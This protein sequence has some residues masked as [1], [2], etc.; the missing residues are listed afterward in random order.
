MRPSRTVADGASGNAVIV[1]AHPGRTPSIPR[2]GDRGAT[3]LAP[4]AGQRRQHAAVLI[5][6]APP[7]AESQLRSYLASYTR[8]DGVVE[9]SVGIPLT[10]AEHDALLHGFPKLQCQ[11]RAGSFGAGEPWF[12]CPFQI[13]RSSTVCLPR[14]TRWATGSGIRC[15]FDR[16]P[17]IPRRCVM[18]ARMCC[19]FGAFPASRNPRRDA[20][21]ARGKARDSHR[22]VRRVRRRG[23]R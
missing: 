1:V 15:M 2:R 23:F 19:V 9:G 14:P 18:R 17:R 5:A 21:T 13:A 11:V 10:R 4:V 6:S 7:Q 8:L 3:C 22:T 16:G 12:A 20:G